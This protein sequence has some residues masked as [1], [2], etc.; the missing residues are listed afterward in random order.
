M[1]RK[2]TFAKQEP[3]PAVPVGSWFVPAVAAS[4]EEVANRFIEFFVVSIRNANAR[5]SYAAAI[6]Q[7]CACLE[8][9]GVGRLF[10]CPPGSAPDKLGVSRANCAMRKEGARPFWRKVFQ[11]ISDELSR[12]LA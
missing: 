2:L 9:H 6:R 10:L 4:G 3:L 11:N 1:I 5:C 8:Q 12:E 7:F